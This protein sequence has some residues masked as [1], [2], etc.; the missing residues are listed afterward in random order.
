MK[1]QHLEALGVPLGLSLCDNDKA[2]GV[3]TVLPVTIGLP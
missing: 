2:I 3:T 1:I